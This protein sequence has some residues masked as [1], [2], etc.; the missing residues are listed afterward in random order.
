MFF[1]SGMHQLPAQ[2]NVI[3]DDQE[4]NEQEKLRKLIKLDFLKSQVGA[5]IN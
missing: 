4:T 2:I 5:Q 1:R 3:L